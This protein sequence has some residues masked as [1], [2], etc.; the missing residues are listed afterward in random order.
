MKIYLKVT[1]VELLAVE[2]VVMAVG[3]LDAVL[4]MADEQVTVLVY[5]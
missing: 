3:F 4:K 1:F 5:Q 2:R